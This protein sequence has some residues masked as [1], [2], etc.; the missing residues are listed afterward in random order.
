MIVPNTVVM[1]V[2]ADSMRIE[3]RLYI[4]THTFDAIV[5]IQLD[6][7]HIPHGW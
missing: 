4:A 2:A 6:V 1:V 7:C 5:T 3:N